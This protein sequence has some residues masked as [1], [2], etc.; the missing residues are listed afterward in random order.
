M[1]P[2]VWVLLP[3]LLAGCALV[4][5]CASGFETASPDDAPRGAE[6]AAERRLMVEQQVEA[7]GVKDARVLAAMRKVPRHWFVPPDLVGEAYEDRAL[8]VGEKQTISQPYIVGLM[9][10][11][12]ALEPG[13]RVLE[14]GTGSGYQA[15]VLSEIAAEVYTIEVVPELAARAKRIFKEHGYK[16]IMAREDDGFRGWP[17][18]APFDAVIVTAAPGFL[19]GPLIGQLKVGG[20]LVIPVGEEIR[21]QNLW[22]ITKDIGGSLGHRLLAPV[23]FVPMT[24]EAQ[25]GG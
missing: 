2:A 3:V 17:G 10:E 19:P 4:L 18:R 11:A 13:T 9:T 14:I 25:N 5:C 15:A 7:R 12:L 24:G 16:N 6:R 8:P 23:R 20:R 1:V 21:N 22:A